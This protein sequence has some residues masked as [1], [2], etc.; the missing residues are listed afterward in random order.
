[1][2]GTDDDIGFAA[3]S[4][5]DQRDAHGA[6]EGVALHLRAHTLHF[7]RRRAA[8]NGFA[9]WRMQCYGERRAA[10]DALEA[11]VG[12]FLRLNGCVSQSSKKE[13]RDGGSTAA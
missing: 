10:A 11:G 13:D 5:A 6:D 12:D 2:R 1:P 7:R 3:A 8:G 9:R 4:T